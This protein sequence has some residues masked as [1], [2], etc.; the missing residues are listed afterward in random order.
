MQK[1]TKAATLQS[2]ALK[3]V[4]PHWSLTRGHSY[5]FVTYGMKHVKIWDKITGDKVQLFRCRSCAWAKAQPQ[6]T[7]SAMFL[8]Q[9]LEASIAQIA[10]A[11]EVPTC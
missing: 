2:L 6:D 3:H 1:I 8:P 5:R 4:A 9:G 7:L 10:V 11:N